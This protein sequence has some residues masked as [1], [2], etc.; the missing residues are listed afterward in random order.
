MGAL[1]ATLKAGK[2]LPLPALSSAAYSRLAC[3][4]LLSSDRRS[5]SHIN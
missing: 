5:D 4:S 1:E 3:T 2:T